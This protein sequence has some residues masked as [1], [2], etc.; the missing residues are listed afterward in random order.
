M[1]HKQ[2][3]SNH[4]GDRG[5]LLVG[6]EA[7]IRPQSER[8]CRGEHPLE[9][10]MDGSLVIH[11]TMANGDGEPGLQPLYVAFLRATVLSL[12]GIHLERNLR[13]W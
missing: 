1:L 2:D 3:M 13:S 9:A 7:L 10:C 12:M 8:S 5:G 11:A 4:T 6:H